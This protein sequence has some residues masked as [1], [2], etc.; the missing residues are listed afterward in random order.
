[1]A[2]R[3]ADEPARNQDGGEIL[4]WG[5][6]SAAA[7]SLA[8]SGGTS[9]CTRD[10][11]VEEHAFVA[12]VGVPGTPVVWTVSWTEAGRSR[13][14]WF[15][16]SSGSGGLIAEFDGFRLAG[17][18]SEDGRDVLLW[19]TK[20][21]LLHVSLS[22]GIVRE[23]LPPAGRVDAHYGLRASAAPVVVT[24]DSSIQTKPEG[25]FSRWLGVERCEP[26]HAT[27]WR[28]EG[29]RWRNIEHE[30]YPECPSPRPPLAVEDEPA[31]R[32]QTIAY[33]KGDVFSYGNDGWV[34]GGVEGG[35]A[36]WDSA[37]RVVFARHGQVNAG[38]WPDAASRAAP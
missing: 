12:P 20:E 31:R 13:W 23:L 11:L 16:A 18:W 7:L 1:V 2:A 14:E 17:D 22:R 29:T 8:L 6:F 9:G 3:A 27:A 25:L 19:T 10:A 38:F 15:D 35:I 33:G 5:R 21:R 32:F 36:L 24:G 28:L 34:L 4:N 26:G 37:G 30:R